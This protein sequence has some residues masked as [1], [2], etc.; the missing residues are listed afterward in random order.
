MNIGTT[1]TA[2]RIKL[3]QNRNTDPQAMYE[4]ADV[5]GKI[6]SCENLRR[7]S[8]DSIVRVSTGIGILD[9]KELQIICGL[10]GR[11][12]AAGYLESIS[13]KKLCK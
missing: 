1:P 4:N 8:S 2:Q 7:P 13:L 10:D 5:P 3:Q 12:S 11:R 6:F 9:F